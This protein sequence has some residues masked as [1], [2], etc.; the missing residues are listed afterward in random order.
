MSDVEF[1]EN[2]FPQGRSSGMPARAI[3]LSGLIIKLGIAKNERQA[4]NVLIGIAISAV[5]A[6]IFVI[7]SSM[8][9]H[10][11]LRVGLPPTQSPANF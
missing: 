3:G 7:K 4:N 2:N 1:D 11:D 6:A 8:I 5:I 9:A 10:Q